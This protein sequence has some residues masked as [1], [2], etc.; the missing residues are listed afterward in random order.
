MHY[1]TLISN[2]DAVWQTNYIQAYGE[3]STTLQSSSDTNSPY[4][5]PYISF[6]T[7]FKNLDVNPKI[8]LQW[9]IFCILTTCYLTMCWNCKRKVYFDQY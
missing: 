2:T 3:N 1:K 4:R 9:M 8:I 7:S 6:N 5:L